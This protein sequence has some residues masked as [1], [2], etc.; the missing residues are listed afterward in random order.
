MLDLAGGTGDIAALL[1]DTVG[2]DGEVVLGDINAGMLA[3]RP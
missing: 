2:D 3:R 1:R